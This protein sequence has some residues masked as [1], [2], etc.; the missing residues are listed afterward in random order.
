MSWKN[1]DN[2]RA[3]LYFAALFTCRDPALAPVE[4]PL[5]ARA[6]DQG[7]MDVR[8]CTRQHFWKASDHEP[9]GVVVPVVSSPGRRPLTAPTITRW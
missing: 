4:E 5:H 6:N 1:Q 9:L 2:P 8:A 3:R 7:D